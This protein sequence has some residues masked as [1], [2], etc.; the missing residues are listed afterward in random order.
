LQYTSLYVRKMLNLLQLCHI[1]GM[2][3]QGHW[4]VI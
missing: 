4:L 1:C 3:K 2:E